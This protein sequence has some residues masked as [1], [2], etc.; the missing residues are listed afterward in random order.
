MTSGDCFGEIAA[1]NAIARTAS[2]VADTECRLLAL[3]GPTF[4][5]AVST[6]RVAMGA[7]VGL[8]GDRLSTTA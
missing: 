2:V 4:V 5:R 6:H 8:S 3:D 7:A 1:L